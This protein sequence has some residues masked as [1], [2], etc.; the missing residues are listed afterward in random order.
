[1]QA[2]NIDPSVASQAQSRIN[3]YSAQFPKK[4]DC[5]FHGITE[6]TS[7]TFDCWIGET[8]TVRTRGN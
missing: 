2:K 3:S 6:G 8:T 4:E 5:F 7:Y 1:E